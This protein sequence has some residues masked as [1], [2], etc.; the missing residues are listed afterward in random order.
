MHEEL[1]LTRTIH[2]ARGCRGH[3]E[4]VKVRVHPPRRVELCPSLFG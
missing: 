3:K 2:F 1:T 4:R